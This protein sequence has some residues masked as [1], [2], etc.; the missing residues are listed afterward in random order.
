MWIK[1]QCWRVTV[2]ERLTGV[3]GVSVLPHDWS[4]CYGIHDVLIA[5]SNSFTQTAR[6]RDCNS[7]NGC[8]L[9]ETWHKWN[10]L[11]S[12]HCSSG[13]SIWRQL[14]AS[15]PSSVHS[16]FCKTCSISINPDPVRL[17]CTPY[18]YSYVSFVG[19]TGADRET[20]SS[21][22]VLFF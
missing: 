4:A 19:N 14:M 16:S 7:F 6:K 20:N 3:S 21:F 12:L 2:L 1:R 22:N 11:V 17:E 9:A 15:S 13:G 5:Q 10:A 18:R 8:R